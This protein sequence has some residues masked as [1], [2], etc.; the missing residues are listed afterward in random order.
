MWDNPIGWGLEV[1]VVEAF[2][3]GRTKEVEIYGRY[4]QR[5]T[6]RTG[7]RDCVPRSSG[8]GCVKEAS[9]EVWRCKGF[10]WYLCP[11]VRDPSVSPGHTGIL[12]WV[13]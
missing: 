5:A 7:G 1:W 3:Q 13:T 4:R 2:M 11:G 10:L 12:R 8:G 6:G 9:G